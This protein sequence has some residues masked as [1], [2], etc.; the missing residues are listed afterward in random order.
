MAFKKQTPQQR[1]RIKAAQKATRIRLR[2]RVFDEVVVACFG[3]VGS[4]TGQHP[5]RELLVRVNEALAELGSERVIQSV[6]SVT[7]QDVARIIRRYLSSTSPT[8][9]ERRRLVRALSQCAKSEKGSCAGAEGAVAAI[10]DLLR[11]AGTKGGAVR[12][13]AGGR[14]KRP[15]GDTSRG[16]SEQGRKETAERSAPPHWSY[17]YLGCSVGDSD[18]TIKRAYRHLAA[19]LHPDKHAARA[20]SPEEILPH[21]RAFQKLQEAY[22]EVWKLRGG[23]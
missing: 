13:P 15:G 3:Y 12:R 6:Q 18:E 9:V 21:L 14:V 22:E 4:I 10:A 11:L 17:Q 16:R 7:L 8:I 23:R 19:K 20:S 2:A 5:G 1:A